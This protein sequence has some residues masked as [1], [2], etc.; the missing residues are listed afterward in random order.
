[1]NLTQQLGFPASHIPL[2]CS[3]EAIPACIYTGG[4][5]IRFIPLMFSDVPLHVLIMSGNHSLV[6]S[7]QS[8]PYQ[9]DLFPTTPF[10][11]LLASRV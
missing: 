8:F 2:A 7:V 4:S 3:V 9:I 5:R 1:M 10:L 11:T 6:L